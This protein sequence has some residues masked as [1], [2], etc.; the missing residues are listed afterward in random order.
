[1]T[2]CIFIL[3]CFK[4]VA[5]GEEL[6]LSIKSTEE[7]YQEIID[8]L[9]FKNSFSNTKSMQEYTYIVVERLKRKGFLFTEI[10]SFENTKDKQFE[11]QLKLH[12][13]YKGVKIKMKPDVFP[14]NLAIPKKNIQDGFI[15]LSFQEYE[16]LANQFIQSLNE[17]GKPF[18]Q[19]K[20]INLKETE[21][22][23]ILAELK[24]ISSQKR[25]IDKI[26]IKGY[27]RF[28]KQFIKNRIGLQEEKVFNTTEIQERNRNFENLN[29]AASIKD[30]EVQFTQDSTKV[31]LYVEK[32]NANVFDGF[33][34]F[35]STEETSLE[36]NGYVDLVLVNNL[37]MGESLN[38]NYKN[39]GREQ[40]RFNANIELPYL[41]KTPVSL[42]A[43]LG[44]FRKD[45][46]FSNTQ[47]N[48]GLNYQISPSIQ[49]GSEAEF[50]S[51]TIL[52]DNNINPIENG[53]DFNAS[54]YGLTGRFFQLSRITGKFF[55]QKKVKLS[56][57][58]GK[59]ESEIE[60]NQFKIN[61][62]TEY[63]IPIAPSLYF[64][65]SLTGA[66]LSSDS[67]IDNELFRFGGMN[68]IRGFEENS[69]VASA[70]GSLRTELRYF[71]SPNLYANSVLDFGYFEN[72]I[73]QLAQNLYSFG[74]GLGIETQAGVLRLIFA[75]GTSKTQDFSFE[76]TQVH[77][78]LNTF[79]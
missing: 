52:L 70:F 15:K 1:M 40:Q 24:F 16:N 56:L 33:I 43:G 5:Q 71:L 74:F 11:L 35:N 19:I 63:S 65:N 38:I 14:S 76:N 18:D 55:N 67:Y 73:N 45:S 47:Q 72:E 54:F 10:I 51:S 13:L 37:H 59:R 41:F 34:G 66:W 27:E 4:L 60:D 9:D 20:L 12:T 6:K 68:S 31:F 75:N 78:S 25:T 28:P 26:I 3:A 8:E 42:E 7:N 46:T 49:I 44:I 57:L 48:L 53:N 79:F 22:D 62:F 58:Y 64:Y 50:I 30:P 36:L 23:H 32:T 61:L 21:D 77:L 39:D 2:T 29:F 69:I 17:A